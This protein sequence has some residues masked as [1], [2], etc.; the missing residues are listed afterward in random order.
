MLTRPAILRC[1]YG[2]ALGFQPVARAVPARCRV[3]VDR[4]GEDVDG[5]DEGDDPFE[6]GTRVI[7]LRPSCGHERGGQEQCDAD[8]DQ[9]DPEGN[10]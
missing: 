4:E 6:N 9:L 8:E 3:Q 10:A 5:K 7:T 2:H 1:S